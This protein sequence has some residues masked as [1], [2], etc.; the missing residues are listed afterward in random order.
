MIEKEK[1]EYYINNKMSYKEISEELNVNIKTVIKYSK[2][3]NLKSLIGS[4]GARKHKFN[5]DYFKVIDTEEKAYWL[6]FIAADGC[7][8]K[9]KKN[10][11][12][13]LQINLK[14][15]DTGHLEKF[16]KCIN[17]DYKI[18]EKNIGISPV[19]QLKIN[20]TKLCKDLIDKN[21]IERKSIV[22]NPPTLRQDLISHFIRGYWDGDGWIK[23][24]KKKGQKNYIQQWGIIGG[25]NALTYFQSNLPVD[26][27]IYYRKDRQDLMTLET[28]AK[29]K[30][31]KL[32]EYLYQ[33]ATVYL[34]RKKDLYEKILSRLIEI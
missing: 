6:G 25:E 28:G 29:E 20:S 9:D 12:F 4:Q 34:D 11:N 10:N 23:Q 8:Y 30:I 13:R 33:N 32:Y 3:Y 14:G 21:I 16:Q 5:E 18:S 22:F 19:C 2:K 26:I 7:V 17:S 31:I 15:S 1:L 27:S 24:Y